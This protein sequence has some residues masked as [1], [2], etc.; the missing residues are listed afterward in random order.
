MT[1]GRREHA[2][3]NALLNKAFAKHGTLIMAHRGTPL[4]SIANNTRGSIRGALLSGADIVEID[5]SGTTDGG[6][7][8]FHDGLEPEFLGVD[9]NVTTMTTA[10]AGEL[11][12]SWLDRPGR[13]VRL[14]EALGLLASFRGDVPFNLDRSWPWW[15]TLLP[16]LDE[17]GMTGQLVLKSKAWEDG[18]EVLAQHPVKYP[19]MPICGSVRDV[20][21]M[22]ART[23]LNVVGVELLARDASHPFVD[24]DWIADVQARGAFVL[25]NAETL[26]TG[27]PLFAGF[28]DETAIMQGPAAGWGPLFDLGVDVIQTDW[29]HV[30]RDYR[31]TRR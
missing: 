15:P 8:S 4:G 31:R 18:V 20:D 23:D 30:L 16:A 19:F 17:L 2:A 7:L 11:S 3:T 12:F 25:A 10:E 29:P 1:Y 14:E 28:D 22:L 27:I 26:N 24:A 6:F 5:I 21:A 13:K 9:R